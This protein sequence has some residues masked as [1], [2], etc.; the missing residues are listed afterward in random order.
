LPFII[1]TTV[2]EVEW[3]GLRWSRV[4]AEETEEMERKGVEY[5]SSP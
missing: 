4:E 3:S 2:F 5:C 1:T